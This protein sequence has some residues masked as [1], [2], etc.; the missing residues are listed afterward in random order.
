MVRLNGLLGGGGCVSRSTVQVAPQ[1][2]QSHVDQI[3]LDLEAI[4]DVILEHL[5][6]ISYK[7]QLEEDDLDYL[8]EV[9]QKEERNERICSKL[10]G[11]LQDKFKTVSVKL[12]RAV[13]LALRVNSRNIVVCL[14]LPQLFS[15]IVEPTILFLNQVAGD[16]IPTES[17]KIEVVAYLAAIFETIGLIN[18]ERRTLGSG[19][20]PNLQECE[21]KLAKFLTH[22]NLQLASQV[23]YLIQAMYTIP[24][25]RQLLYYIR[26]PLRHSYDP[27]GIFERTLV[28]T[29]EEIQD[30]FRNYAIEVGFPV[31]NTQ[32]KKPW[33]EMVQVSRYFISCGGHDLLKIRLAKWKLELGNPFALTLLLNLFV[34]G[35][36]AF[37]NEAN[38]HKAVENEK[39]RKSEKPLEKVKGCM[40]LVLLIFKEHSLFVKDRR[41]LLTA[42]DFFAGFLGHTDI[43]IRLIAKELYGTLYKDITS[44]VPSLAPA[45]NRPDMT[46]TRLLSITSDGTLTPPQSTSTDP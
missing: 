36:N 1:D 3:E 30:R 15:R 5:D 7:S 2:S 40:G 13:S 32:G 11:I 43:S 4:Q 10:L 9:L 38:M 41:V 27:I 12:M 23:A 28:Y 8:L 35:V 24:A 20:V 42:Y 6:N 34:E 19:F 18:Q 39:G 44:A 22:T 14:N 37:V 25:A 29:P 16:N 31:L 45:D 21:S 17:E 26:G 33:Y 46:S